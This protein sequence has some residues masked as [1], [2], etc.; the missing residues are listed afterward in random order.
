MRIT[1]NWIPRKTREM[2]S[3]NSG[4]ALMMAI[5]AMTMLL[6]I[7][8][9]MLF[10]TN[11]E[12][13]VSSQS[14]NQVKAYYAAKAGVDISLLRIH[15][16]K[17][18]LGMI[19]SA[20]PNKSM[21][22]PIWQMPFA[23]P[24]IV[25]ATASGIDQGDIKKSVKES[26][27]TSTYIAT[28]DSESS[29]LDINDL[30]SSN[31]LLSQTVHTQLMQMFQ[32][33]I[34]GDE[35]FAARYRGFDFNS[36]LNNI[37]DWVDADKQGRNGGDES[38]PYSDRPNSQY[39]PPNAPFK[40]LS[41][42]HQVAGVTDE[43]YSLLEPRITI[44]GAKGVNVNY[45]GKQVLMSLSPDI[46]AERAEKILEGRQDPNRGP[47]KDLADFTK[48][49]NT[50][51]ISG[52]PFKST[53]KDNSNGKDADADAKLALIF[54]PEFNFRIKSQGTAG[55]VTKEITAI[56]YDTAK[57]KER[58]KLFQPTPPPLPN[59]PK[60]PAQSAPPSPTTG[61]DTSKPNIVYWNE[62]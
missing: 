54:D 23:W 29:K 34:D 56:V 41:E 9:D 20:L 27:M 3:D 26:L 53:S 28:I 16:Y 39:L 50:L 18:A 47:F 11:V 42:L 12:V 35:K 36:V 58:L 19:G 14:I 15:I 55:K 25:P 10:E 38:A 62:T 13:Q 46:T 31:Q 4:A 43:I 30:G 22:D 60:P 5:F 37:A 61:S 6:A 51:G 32:S 17:K 24:P 2:L 7:A 59:Q 45:A 52:D 1:Q 21:L 40:T 57:I 8:M 48:F 33:R 44:Y 49:L